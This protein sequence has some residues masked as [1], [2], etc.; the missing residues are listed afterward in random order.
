M[1]EITIGEW[2]RRS[3]KWHKVESLI[4]DEPVLRCGRVMARALHGVPLEVAETEPLTRAIGQPQDC[5][6]CAR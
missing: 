1:S 6:A 4:N 5:K 3:G 2:I